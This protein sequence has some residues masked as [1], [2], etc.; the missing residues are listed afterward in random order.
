MKIPLKWHEEDAGKWIMSKNENDSMGCVA[1]CT[2]GFYSAFRRKVQKNSAKND[3][4]KVRKQME[5]VTKERNL[6]QVSINQIPPGA[7][8]QNQ[9]IPVQYQAQPQ[10]QPQQ[11][12]QQQLQPQ[13]VQ[14][15]V[16]PKPLQPQQN[17]QQ[18]IN[19]GLG[20]QPQPQSQQ[21]PIQQSEPAPVPVYPPRAAYPPAN[22][23]EPEVQYHY[24]SPQ[25]SPRASPNVV[26]LDHHGGGTGSRTHKRS[27]SAPPPKNPPRRKSKEN[28]LES[29]NSEVSGISG[30]DGRPYKPK[31]KWQPASE[32]EHRK[33]DRMSKPRNGVRYQN[34]GMEPPVDYTQSIPTRA[35][36]LDSRSRHYGDAYDNYDERKP[37]KNPE[38][39][40]DGERSNRREMDPELYSR[41]G[42]EKVA[43][44]DFKHHRYKVEP[45][46][47]ASPIQRGAYQEDF[48][49][50]SGFEGGH[51][52]GAAYG[53]LHK[54]Q[55][56]Y[57]DDDYI[58]E[59]NNR[60][61]M[62]PQERAGYRPSDQQPYERNYGNFDTN[63]PYERMREDAYRN[64]RGIPNM[65]E[66][67]YRI[68]DKRY[69]HYNREAPD[70]NHTPRDQ[71]PK[72]RYNDMY[73][74]RTAHN[75]RRSSPQNR[76]TPQDFY[77]RAYDDDMHQHPGNGNR[78]FISPQRTN[79]N[80]NQRHE[81]QPILQKKKQAQTQ[82][83]T[84][85]ARSRADPTKFEKVLQEMHK[86][87][88]YSSSSPPRAGA[89]APT[90]DR[91]HS[92]KQNVYQEAIHNPYSQPINYAKT[93][94]STP[95]LERTVSPNPNRPNFDHQTQQHFDKSIPQNRSRE[96]PD[97]LNI[98]NRSGNTQSRPQSPLGSPVQSPR[99][100]LTAIDD[101][102]DNAGATSQ[103][104]IQKESS[105]SGRYNS[106]TFLGRSDNNHG[107]R[108]PRNNNFEVHERESGAVH[109][110]A[111]KPK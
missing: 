106:F 49:L 93:K 88:V 18:P 44:E 90:R 67:H 11:Q 59:E 100:Y 6:R 101:F 96:H 35:R 56:P 82:G 63:L 5:K 84:R 26:N 62:N 32:E 51:P 42:K 89:T 24:R 98:W 38:P 53:R 102:T 40:I 77:N 10:P 33:G 34:Q 48:N 2:G 92:P 3:A 87:Q 29:E 50:H 81:A 47:S 105:R 4:Q 107:F 25:F 68:G 30:G 70:K 46:R 65:G 75:D 9:P 99:D 20:G 86:D 73:N 95:N 91:A 97:S 85:P 8:P 13:Q 19:V 78:A 17:P 71:S 104:I 108:D 12:Q 52:H 72:G 80:M 28:N 103:G 37:F 21:N 39:H 22:N 1:G 14:R 83:K 23:R 66:E 45:P 55:T 57:E 69:Q 43:V 109:S 41:K 111:F 61:K 15:P 58:K 7:L 94:T 64:Q 16:P 27:E 31:Q 74:E 76:R 36:G 54:M 60:S 79:Q 110:F